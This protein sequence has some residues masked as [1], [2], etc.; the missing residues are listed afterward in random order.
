MLGDPLV[1]DLV[2]VQR[3]ELRFIK[4][5]T[6]PEFP[7][8]LGISRGEVTVLTKDA[9]DRDVQKVLRDL[10]FVRKDA[11][12][13]IYKVKYEFKKGRGF[14]NPD[15]LLRYNIRT[16]IV[17]EDYRAEKWKIYSKDGFYLYS[18]R[19]D[20]FGTD[21]LYSTFTTKIYVDEAA[22]D[23]YFLTEENIESTTPTTKPRSFLIKNGKLVAVE[24]DKDPVNRLVN[25]DP[26]LDPI[27]TKVQN[28]MM[29]RFDFGAL[30]GTEFAGHQKE[31]ERMIDLIRSRVQEPIFVGTVE[32]QKDLPKFF[33]IVQWVE[34]H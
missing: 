32:E 2:I 3:G 16:G 22:H 33:S 28:S 26:Y 23:L 31:A 10:I 8:P 20:V 11:D 30:S 25:T 9:Y 24:E 19:P 12:E 27:L 13:F 4:W 29:V 7:T 21:R 6:T 1:R 34:S 15:I 5:F 17:C 18:T 14:V